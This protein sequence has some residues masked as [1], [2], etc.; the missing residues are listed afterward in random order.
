MLKRVV[1]FIKKTISRF[2]LISFF[3]ALVLLFVLIAIGSSIRQ[4][5]EGTQ[6][7]AAQIKETEVFSFGDVPYLNLTGRVDKKRV[8]SIDATASGIVQRIYAN[9][10]DDVY[11]GKTLVSISDTYGGA[12][13]SAIDEQIAERTKEIQD[14][15]YEKNEDVLDFQRDEVPRTSD[16][17][18]AIARK[19][20]TIQKRNLELNRDTIDLTLEKAQ[21]ADALHYPSAPTKGIVE[22]IYVKPGERVQVGTPLISFL[23]DNDSVTLEMMVS[24]NVAKMISVNEPSFVE[25]NNL[26]IEVTPIY[27]SREATDGQQYSV[28]Y[29]MPKEY[30]DQVANQGFVDVRVPLENSAANKFAPMVPIDAVQLTQDEAYVFL[31]VD[32]VAESRKVKLGNVYGEFVQIVEG[33]ERNEEIVLNRNVFHGDRISKIGNEIEVEL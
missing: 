9:E 18:N 7:E 17:E 26:R 13:I 32:G 20:V 16:E 30:A 5:E 2:P 3:G 29:S 11:A 31:F 19:Q 27:I 25:I 22:K 1:N 10:G 28:L 12:N 33:L 8:I 6:E 15:T 23:T 24:L 14:I 21:I 4:P